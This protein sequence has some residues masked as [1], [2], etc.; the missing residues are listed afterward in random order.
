M[1]LSDVVSRSITA[2][3]PGGAATCG[4]G[5]NAAH[6][7]GVGWEVSPSVVGE[8]GDRVVLAEIDGPGV[9]RHFWVTV[10]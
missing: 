10:D 9:L 8:A 2:Q 5:A 6:D 4:T 7:L 1:L 3:N